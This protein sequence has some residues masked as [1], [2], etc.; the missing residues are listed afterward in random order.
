MTNLLYQICREKELFTEDLRVLSDLIDKKVAKSRFLVIG[1]GGSIGH[2][3]SKEIFRR[4][5]SLLHVVDLSENGL[6]ELTRDIRSDLGYRTKNYDTFPLDVQS[7]YFYEFMNKNKYDYV[8]NLSALKHVRSEGNSFVMQR[9]I[10]TNIIATVASYKAAVDTGVKK[11]FCVSTDKAANPTNFMGATKRAMEL[12]LMRTNNPIPVS[13]ARFANVAFSN[14]S[15]LQGF[16]NR[17]EKYQP[18]TAPRDVQR[19]FVTEKEAGLLCL[20]S[21]IIGE[22]NHTIFPNC[23]SEIKLTKFSDIVKRFLKCRNFT[24]YECTSEI[25][26]RNYFAKYLGNGKWPVY[27]F[28]TNTV[29]EKLYEEF[30]TNEE[31][32]IKKEYIDF[33]FIKSNEIKAEQD[34]EFFLESIQ[35]IN[36]GHK[37][38]HNLYISELRKFVPSFE[39]KVACQSL[40]E[41]M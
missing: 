24:P 18:I 12:C 2:A 31:E 41:K 27:Y 6:V 29:G 20:F 30:Y 23:T 34:I 32:I 10:D 40:N 5:A 36:P 26:A 33:A 17:F 4:G 16:K 11:Y 3:V 19:Y 1:G 22:D 8:L 7:Q 37:D 28:D 35:K 15:L 39:H 13:S 38:S 14:G 21:T 9:M 25:E